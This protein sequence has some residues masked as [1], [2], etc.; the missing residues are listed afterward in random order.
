VVALIDD[1]IVVVEINICKELNSIF[2]DIMAK[3]AVESCQDS[4]KIKYFLHTIILSSYFYTYYQ[5]VY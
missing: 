5:L 4:Y 1:I 3:T 2:F